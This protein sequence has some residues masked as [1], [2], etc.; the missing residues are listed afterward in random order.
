MD[1]VNESFSKTMLHILK[2]P[3]QQII[4]DFLKNITIQWLGQFFMDCGFLLIL[5]HAFTMPQPRGLFSK[6][7]AHE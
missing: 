3:K 2:H 1:I 6:L 7:S 5:C 4:N